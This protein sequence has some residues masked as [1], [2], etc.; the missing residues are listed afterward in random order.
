M[1]AV[2][3]PN[4]RRMG[5]EWAP[6]ERRLC[7]ERSAECAVPP[8][9]ERNPAAGVYFASILTNIRLS[10]M[11]ADHL[12]IIFGIPSDYREHLMTAQ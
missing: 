4:G 9:G 10:F 6:D 5:A 12:G 11:M 7:P 8:G 1:G 2:W 3:A